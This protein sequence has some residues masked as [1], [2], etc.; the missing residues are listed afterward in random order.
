MILP[1][2][3]LGRLGYDSDRFRF[4]NGYCL[5]R[6]Q[7]QPKELDDF[8]EQYVSNMA[9]P[10]EDEEDPEEAEGEAGGNYPD[11]MDSCFYFRH[12]T[13]RRHRKSTVTTEIMKFVDDESDDLFYRVEVFEVWNDSSQWQRFFLGKCKATTCGWEQMHHTK[14]TRTKNRGGSGGHSSLFAII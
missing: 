8:V 1:E 4:R 14:E 7:N 5:M 12:C 6:L 9:D 13:Q 11:M 3:I 10:F 2:A